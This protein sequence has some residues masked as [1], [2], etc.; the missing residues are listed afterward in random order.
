MPMEAD[1]VAPRPDEGRSGPVGSSSGGEASGLLARRELCRSGS[2]DVIRGHLS[3]L[4][5]PARIETLTERADLSRS[6]LS[7]V[8][9]DS[10]TIG[11]LRFG[12]E[13]LV[14]P[15]QLGAY[16]VNVPV[17]GAVAS[18]CGSRETVAT[19]RRAAVFTPREHTVLP[20]WSAD[21]AVICIKMQKAAVERELE[22]LLGHPVSSDVR[23]DIALDLGSPAARSWL[24]VLRL[25]IDELDQPGSL[26]ERSL[27]Y[28]MHLEKLVI[29]AFLHAQRHDFQAELTD[30]A[31]AAR[32]RT[33]KR[34]VDLIMADPAANHTVGDLARSAGVSA[35]RLQMAFQE[36]L[37]TT[38]TAF[39]R[40][41]KLE[42]AR[43]DLLAG[44]AGVT[45]TAYRWGF[46]H[47]GRFA[48]AY[49]D[50]YGECP[51]ETYRCGC[52]ESA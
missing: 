10:L 23:F 42:R 13:A 17:A 20:R 14:D 31:P 49:R 51:S 1:S 5:Y 33:V 41:L 16:H 37:H 29:S 9:L 15:G 24:A 19:V 18:V 45:E 52:G 48:A 30:P 38:P 34:V 12:S 50:T 32:P 8:R 44:A 21:A 47:P 26:V 39:Q 3:T 25:L 2:L 22:A 28:R 7:A 11:F 27:A 36:T 43:E 46:G 35:R 6:V 4:F 40:R